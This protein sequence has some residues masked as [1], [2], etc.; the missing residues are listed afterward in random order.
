MAPFPFS[1]YTFMLP[2]VYGYALKKVIA[3][4]SETHHNKEANYF[5]GGQKMAHRKRRFGDRYDGRL[6]R[7]LDPFYKIIPY[8]MRTRV[9]AQNYFEDRIEVSGTEEFI[10]NKRKTANQPITFLHVIIAAMVRTISQKPGLNRFIAGQKIYARNDIYISFALKKELK[11]DSAET[12]L[13]VKFQ[14]TDTF[15]DVVSKVNQ[16]ILENK[17]V[18]LKND[19]DKLAKLIMRIPGFLVR[20]VVWLLR[21]LDY[22]GLMPKIINKLSPFH[23]SIFITDLGSVGIEPVFH[24]LYEFGTTSSFIA[25]GLKSKEKVINSSNEIVNKK[26]VRLR[27]VTD[28]RTVDGHYYALAFKLYRNLIKHPEKLELPPEHIYEDVD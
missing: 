6:L 18:G 1:K 9:D 19:T 17:D 15:D 28:E 10:R 8:I 4:L 2:L 13:K 11:E 27:V 12:T 16:A 20:F 21:S 23:T 5:E 3:C 7:T 24:H 26:Y 25:F 22:I 14:P